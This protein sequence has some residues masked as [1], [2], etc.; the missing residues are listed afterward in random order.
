C[1][2][3][4]A[5]ALV[6]HKY[7]AVACGIGPAF[8]GSVGREGIGTGVALIAIVGEI[9]RH[10]GLGA[11]HCNEG[12]AYRL[13]LPE[14][15]AEVCVYIIGEADVLDIG[16]GEYVRGQGRDIA[17]PDIVGGEDWARPA[18]YRGSSG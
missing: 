4:G 7:M 15:G 8:D 11:G 5:V 14:A 17:V 1:F 3:E 13:A 12:Y 10:E 16:V 2:I 9:D 18:A 6:D